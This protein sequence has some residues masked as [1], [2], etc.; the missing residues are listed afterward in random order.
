MFPAN[1]EESA[2][3][4]MSSALTFICVYTVTARARAGRGDMVNALKETVE[5]REPC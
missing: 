2:W 3:L 5:G 4:L 1:S